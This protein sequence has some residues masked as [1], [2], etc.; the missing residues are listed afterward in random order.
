MRI[1]QIK[2]LYPVGEKK[3]DCFVSKLSGIIHNGLLGTGLSVHEIIS[4]L[5]PEP[6]FAFPSQLLPYHFP[7][8]P[9]SQFPITFLPCSDMDT[10]FALGIFLTRC[11]W[12]E[13]IIGLYSI[14][15]K[16]Q[17]TEVST[18]A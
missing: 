2:K 8:L 9:T 15:F 6:G 4:S 12:I 17:R 14:I 18:K 1:T 11:L 5:R 3:K 16:R 7:F 13:Y 10:Q